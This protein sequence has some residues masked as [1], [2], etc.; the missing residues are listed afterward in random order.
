MQKFR[1]WLIGS[2]NGLYK[3]VLE[4][5][6]PSRQTVLIVVLAFVT[7]LLWAYVLSPTIYYDGDPSQLQQGWQNEWVQL[8]ADRYAAVSSS[9]ATGAEFDQSIINLLSAVDDP[10][11]IVDAQGINVPGFRQLAKQAEALAKQPPPRPSIVA[12]ILPFI[13]GSIVMVIASVV[14]ALVG[15]ILIYPNIIEPLIKRIRGEVA[16][17]D[18]ATQKTI[19]AMRAARAAEEKAK[20]TASTDAELGD[21][22][23]RKM[24]VYLMGRGQYDDSFEVEDSNDMF[25]G[26][27]G[28]AIAETIGEGDPAKVTAIEVWL[29]DKEDF[30]RTLTGVFATQHAFNDP[31][32]RSKLETKG[33]LMLMQPGA[34]IMLETNA[35]RLRA[36]VVEMAY[37]S[38]EAPA[39]SFLENSTIEVAVWQKASAPS[40]VLAG[41]PP[42]LPAEK[43]LA[44]DIQFDPP[45]PLPSAPS[46]P[47]TP[48]MPAA[49]PPPVSTPPTRSMPP[50][51]QPA[52]PT[53]PSQDDDPF[54][55]T[56][57]F[58]PVG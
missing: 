2:Y 45:P 20:E 22:V 7:G 16:V 19:D 26:E 46:S 55:G 54:G 52:P 28:A 27:C 11:G 21:P 36:R 18:A 17:S 6:M 38:G 57:D 34:E 9:S 49:S 35:L 8:L 42:P 4:P 44:P 32:I 13:V 23:T 56:G 14:I 50:T 47:A 5:S 30:V 29:F 37:G 10:V 31:T 43:P 15:R 39:N 1:E 33:D 12:S 58:T 48:A 40:A 51:R 24:S 53:S 41:G 3:I 25:L